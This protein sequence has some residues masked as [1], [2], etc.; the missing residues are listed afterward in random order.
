MAQRREPLRIRVHLWHATQTPASRVSP[1]LCVY[2]MQQRLHM[3]QKVQKTPKAPTCPETDAC[4]HPV[5]PWSICAHLGRQI[6]NNDNQSF[7]TSWESGIQ[8]DF[9]LS[10]TRQIKEARR[11]GRRKGRREGRSEGRWPRSLADPLTLSGRAGTAGAEQGQGREHEH[12]QHVSQSQSAAGRCRPQTLPH[13]R[14]RY[15][16]GEPNT[17]ARTAEKP[18]GSS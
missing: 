6:K 1:N 2:D 7:S 13:R 10:A 15:A 14:Q 4:P 3:H 9:Q 8:S 16:W 11:L 18:L 12:L 5:R 17:D